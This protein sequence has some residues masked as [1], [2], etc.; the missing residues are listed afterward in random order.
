MMS[1]STSTQRLVASL[2][3]KLYA[4]ESATYYVSGLLDEGVHSVMDVENA[5]VLVSFKMYC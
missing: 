5:L 1:S 2:S 3:L 4:L